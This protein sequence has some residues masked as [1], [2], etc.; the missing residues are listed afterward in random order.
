MVGKLFLLLRLGAFFSTCV[1]I[2][3]GSLS[4]FLYLAAIKTQSTTENSGGVGY[5]FYN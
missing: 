5:R 1:S 3:D 4:G 2:S